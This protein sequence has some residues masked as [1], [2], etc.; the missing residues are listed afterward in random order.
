MKLISV[1]PISP[2]RI[3]LHLYKYRKNDQYNIDLQNG[4]IHFSKLKDLNDPFDGSF[5]IAAFNKRIIIYAIL[6]FFPAM[7]KPAMNKS[8]I[9][10]INTYL[11]NHP[12][13]LRNSNLVAGEIQ[14]IIRNISE[15]PIRIEESQ[16]I[17]FHNLF[18]EYIEKIGKKM[19]S[20]MVFCSSL[21]IDNELM[22][23]HYADGNRG[24]CAEIDSKYFDQIIKKDNGVLCGQVSYSSEF[25][26][27]YFKN[28][29]FRNKMISGKEIN[30]AAKKACF[31]KS[32]EWSYEKEYRFLVDNEG[33]NENGLPKIPS[34]I[35]LIQGINYVRK[36]NLSFRYKEEIFSL[37]PY[38][39]IVI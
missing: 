4:E 8:T 10:N 19:D 7:N 13:F 30:E 5:A 34:S 22:W 2:Q 6:Y 39:V 36:F 14:E 12:E 23:S 20:F 11:N 27:L 35:R 16:I 25:P 29:N 33:I 26:L 18:D 17:E 37:N 31:I 32:T 1:K 28:F 38:K 21:A 15:S 9:N 3:P 24:I